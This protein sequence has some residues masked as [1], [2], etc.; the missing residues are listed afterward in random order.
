MNHCKPSQPF[1]TKLQERY[2]K[3]NK[4]ERG[5]ILNEFVA[6]TGYHRKHAIAL[7][8]GKRHYRDRSKPIKRLRARYYTSEDKRWVLWL[9]ELFDF[10]L[11]SRVHQILLHLDNR[12]ASG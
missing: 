9:A 7:L 4:K 3:A 11:Y 5:H 2:A 8:R 1:L 6:T 10:I 12:I